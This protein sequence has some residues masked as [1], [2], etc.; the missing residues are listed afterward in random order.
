MRNSGVAYDVR[1]K[2]IRMSIALEM[3]KL[4][5]CSQIEKRLEVKKRDEKCVISKYSILQLANLKAEFTERVKKNT[6]TH[7]KVKPKW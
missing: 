1:C 5:R 4:M 6:I 7:H 3:R 2:G